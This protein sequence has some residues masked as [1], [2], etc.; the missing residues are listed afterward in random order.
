MG[1]FRVDG[2]RAGS[3]CFP[4]REGIRGVLSFC[5]SMKIHTPPAPSQEGKELPSGDMNI[6]LNHHLVVNY[7]NKFYESK[8]L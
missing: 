7:K 3:I 1:V 8:E 2:Y 4:S 6:P 5:L